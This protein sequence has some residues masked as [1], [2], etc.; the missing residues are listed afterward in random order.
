M[1]GNCLTTH[2]LQAGDSIYVPPSF[3]AAP[4][5]V[6]TICGA[7]AD[8]VSY[9][10]QSGDT[11]F[12]LALPYDVDMETLKR[13]N[14]LHNHAISAGDTLHVPTGT[15]V[16]TAPLLLSPED[17]ANFPAGQRAVVRWTWEGDLG[18]HEHF[19]VRLWKEGAPHHGVG[20]SKE[21]HYAVHG[22]PGVTYYWSVVVIY[23]EDGEMLKELSP[24]SPPRKITWGKPE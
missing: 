20:W 14:C 1:L 17:G 22:D 6:P 16:S 8:W 9:R 7:P 5:P 12:S 13:A 10:V 3:T 19:D 24:Q 15:S 4:P 21:E 11:L 23:G 2:A 18:E